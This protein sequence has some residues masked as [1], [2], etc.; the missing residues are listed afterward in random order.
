MTSGPN[1]V[2]QAIVA[3][4]GY[5][6]QSSSVQ[7][8]L[9]NL[10][11]FAPA[12]TIE[13]SAL[14]ELGRAGLS[15]TLPPAEAAWVMPNVLVFAYGPGWVMLDIRSPS[16][17]MHYGFL[18]ASHVSQSSKQAGG[19]QKH[20]MTPSH[21][22]SIAVLH[23]GLDNASPII[24]A[25]GHT[26][27]M[28][29]VW[30][31]VSSRLLH[32]VV[33]NPWGGQD[34]SVKTD[35]C[36]TYCAFRE[37]AA[38]G[39]ASAV[40]QV[41]AA[42]VQVSAREGGKRKR[43]V[44]AQPAALGTF[45]WQRASAVLIGEAARYNPADG[46]AMSCLAVQSIF[47]GGTCVDQTCSGACTPQV[48]SEGMSHSRVK[49]EDPIIRIVAHYSHGRVS[50]LRLNQLVP[51]DLLCN[52]TPS[53]AQSSQHS[54]SVIGYGSQ[55]SSHITPSFTL[56]GGVSA[57][58]QK[59]LVDL[60]GSFLD[61]P[62]WMLAFRDL[63]LESQQQVMMLHFM[64]ISPRADLV[65]SPEEATA[66]AALKEVGQESLDATFQL[67][68]G[69]L[70]PAIGGADFNQ[71]LSGYVHNDCSVITP[72]WQ[73]W[74]GLAS[75]NDVSLSLDV[76]P[77][78]GEFMVLDGRSCIAVRSTETGQ[79]W[80]N[81]SFDAL[82]VACATQHTAQI[83]AA[84]SDCPVQ[85][86]NAPQGSPFGAYVCMQ[87]SPKNAS[88]LFSR[89]ADVS[90][91]FPR[92][93]QAYY[94][95]GLDTTSAL[96]ACHLQPSSGQPV[97]HRSQLQRKSLQLLTPASN[98]NACSTSR[99]LGH[100]AKQQP[101]MGA[102]SV[103]LTLMS[104]FRTTPE[105]AVGIA[106]TLSRGHWPVLLQGEDVPRRT[107][108]CTGECAGPFLFEGLPQSIL[109][110]SVL[111][112]LG[113]PTS[114]LADSSDPSRVRRQSTDSMVRVQQL[115]VPGFSPVLDAVLLLPGDV[116][117]PS[118]R[119]TL[120]RLVL[121]ELEAG[122][123]PM[124]V[125]V[126]KITP[127]LEEQLGIATWGDMG[128][129]PAAE[130]EWDAEFE[131]EEQWAQQTS[132]DDSGCTAHL[133]PCDQQ[134]FVCVTCTRRQAECQFYLACLGA[135]Q[136]KLAEHRVAAQTCGCC[137]ADCQCPGINCTLGTSTAWGDDDAKLV[138]LL[139][140]PYEDSRF[141]KLRSVEAAMGLI[142][143]MQR[144]VE[145]E[146][147][148]VIEQVG[149]AMA[150]APVKPVG[151][152]SACATTC[153]A[154]HEVL[155]LGRKSPFACAC[156]AGSCGQ[157]FTKSHCTG[158]D[159]SSVEPSGRRIQGEVVPDNLVEFVQSCL[160]CINLCAQGEEAIACRLASAP[161]SQL[162][163]ASMPDQTFVDRFCYCHQEE[164][165]PMI[166]CE[167]CED[168]F[169]DS[170]LD[171]QVNFHESEVFSVM[172]LVCSDCIRM[173]LPFLA[174]ERLYELRPP[175]PA[176]PLAGIS[177]Q[178]PAS[179]R[180]LQADLCPTSVIDS[181]RAD[182]EYPAHPQRRFIG[183]VLQHGALLHAE[184]WS[185]LHERSKAL[186]LASARNVPVP[187]EARSLDNTAF[188][189]S[190]AACLLDATLPLPHLPPA[191]DDSVW[192][193][194]SSDRD[195]SVGSQDEDDADEEDRP[196]RTGL[197]RPW[198]FRL[199]G[200]IAESGVPFSAY[201]S[202]V[203]HWNDTLAEEAENILGALLGHERAGDVLAEMDKHLVREDQLS[204]LAPG[205]AT[206]ALP[207]AQSAARLAAAQ[208]NSIQN[209]S[210]PAVAM[211][212]VL[213]NLIGALASQ[214]S[215][216]TISESD[217]MRLRR[218]L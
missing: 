210:S 124:N 20:R 171:P 216:G 52:P 103:F 90:C 120:A 207:P 116:Q 99:S 34:V 162:L 141:D 54:T 123:M 164:R 32:S 158:F 121:Q 81:L 114:E 133:G 125:Q 179:P 40:E 168:W 135:L 44:L 18:G 148:G 184:W 138:Q 134:V 62:F 173:R 110:E 4:F 191:T 140:E 109:P 35:A 146:E 19:W 132:V 77:H 178:V 74:N 86:L 174:D 160:E 89:A 15:D 104:D 3:C 201:S 155:A 56:D 23:A 67:G 119:R 117:D 172:T 75:S 88:L 156:A 218:Q 211:Q 108:I 194:L 63:Y 212:Q 215:S 43:L 175:L 152:C 151:V 192:A 170:C 85:V 149:A 78:G 196:Y 1:S 37:P 113:L 46:M 82:V 159:L 101:W 209:A 9:I 187:S 166:Q 176:A 70:K 182:S 25:T 50:M 202:S 213:R 42:A 185:V 188:L 128:A 161:T 65:V 195:G 92:Q 58:T 97:P 45:R 72:Q 79:R 26:N 111:T 144:I 29:H 217:V 154:N 27:G 14:L 100:S 60:S 16:T 21:A 131:V 200:A 91:N 8:K 7:I 48:G 94:M 165:R 106:A 66:L 163:P 10:S 5:N 118:K 112:E 31:A 169:H 49:W 199:A 126:V 6:H 69:V 38:T 64:G 157:Y 150:G 177:Q 22:C 76:S 180:P 137:E 208:L 205:L 71:V 167:M 80:Q 30:E 55:Q 84:A 181:L 2:G 115:Q 203:Q 102:E 153:H 83:S 139:V 189:S 214:N 28:V 142:G 24:L 186:L 143:R 127:S 57:T 197:L 17:A 51:M 204:A 53:G 95:D 39:S 147:G 145:E 33:S 13:L 206:P 190:A 105:C 129:G 12:R 73:I 130:L 107:T 198:R 41:S 96:Y 183:Y 36:W 68:A 59:A 93:L 122:H 47:K 98:R 87:R 136:R 11:T 61:A 193:D